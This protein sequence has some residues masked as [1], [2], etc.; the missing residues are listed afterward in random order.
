ML[1][2]TSF[3]FSVMMFDINHGYR[4]K[5]DAIRL[6]MVHISKAESRGHHD[7]GLNTR[8][9]YQKKKFQLPQY[10]PKHVHGYVLNGFDEIDQWHAESNASIKVRQSSTMKELYREI[11]INKHG[12]R[13]LPKLSLSGLAEV[14]YFYLLI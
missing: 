4:R 12:L 14:V 7:H 8:F 6:E 9:F 5:E 10:V 2:S 1:N 3:V 11:K 13:F